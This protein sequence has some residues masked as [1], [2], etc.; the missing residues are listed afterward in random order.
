MKFNWA[1]AW[2]SMI[3]IAVF[4]AGM[5]AIYLIKAAAVW[6][7][8]HAGI[9]PLVI[10]AVLVIVGYFVLSGLEVW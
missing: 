1:E 5:F 8:D 7:D 6:I 3:P 4:V 10:A 9:P 2:K